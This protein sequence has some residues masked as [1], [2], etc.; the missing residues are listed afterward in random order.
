MRVGTMEGQSFLGRFEEARKPRV[1][2][3][4]RPARKAPWGVGATSPALGRCPGNDPSTFWWEVGTLCCQSLGKW[5]PWAR[6]CG[7]GAR[8]REVAVGA[9]MVETS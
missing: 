3:A 5:G 6:Q 4:V 7:C 1:R 2:A 9:Q 8:I